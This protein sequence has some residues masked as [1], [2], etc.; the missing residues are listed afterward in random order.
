MTPIALALTRSAVAAFDTGGPRPAATGAPRM[1]AAASLA[2]LYGSSAGG[3][4]TPGG[5]VFTR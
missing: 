5:S 3:L 2:V 4:A 1:A